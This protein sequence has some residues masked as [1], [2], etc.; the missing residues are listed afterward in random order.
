MNKMLYFNKKNVY[1]IIILCAIFFYSL[2]IIKFHSPYEWYGADLS[3]YIGTSK[4][5]IEK[6]S[7]EFDYSPQTK[8][9]PG[10]PLFLSG[11]TYICGKHVN[12][13][14]IFII[15]TAMMGLLGIGLSYLLI[16]K[17]SPLYALC[18]CFLFLTSPVMF[19]LASQSI[20]SDLPYFAFF[21]I[22]I[23]LGIKLES[24]NNNSLKKY[25]ISIFF[26]I[27]LVFSI[28]L[29]SIGI[30]LL[31][32]IL[33]YILLP[34]VMRK[35][36][37]GIKRI[38]LFIIPFFIGSISEI[39]WL[40]WSSYHRIVYYPGQYFDSYLTQIKFINPHRP[41]LGYASF[42]DIMLR[43]FNNISRQITHIWEMIIHTNWLQPFWLS[44]FVII[45][46][47]L[48]C[49]CIY[50]KIKAKNINFLFLY[51]IFYM[52]IILVWPFDEGHRFII[53]IFPIFCLYLFEGIDIFLTQVNKNFYKVIF[54]FGIISGVC[55]VISSTLIVLFNLRGLQYYA[56]IIFWIGIFLII[57]VL[58]IL[59]KFQNFKVI[60]NKGNLLL[61][62]GKLY[63]SVIVF[64]TFLFCCYGIVQEYS[65]ANKNVHLNPENVLH[66]YWAQAGLWLKEHVP[67]NCVIMTT[68]YELIHYKSGCKTIP[69]PVSNSYNLISSTI[70]KHKPDYIIII[71]E[72]KYPYFFP[73]DEERFNILQK[74]HDFSFSLVYLNP[75]CKI[76]KIDISPGK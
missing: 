51:F 66:Y 17:Y 55:T 43:F 42:A 3:Y 73:T 64:F 62:S 48:L 14:D 2:I 30:A 6:H 19:L 63:K 38:K 74:Y 61:K 4:S 9:P 27:S 53:P 22:T 45:T 32:A 71:N 49:L 29:R 26:T 40:I 11:L 12:K 24:T 60:F 39:A 67:Q 58:E 28:M 23:I 21:I 50:K 20:G 75:E 70:I 59:L 57:I 68:H 7:Y 10:Y 18:I 47:C 15:C 44:P 54:N 36:E 16:Q 41:T 5:I 1:S 13:T 8:F 34:F 35:K 72:G 25:I 37:S 46:I 76:Y 33:C 52:G 31:A 65:I 56:S 69:F